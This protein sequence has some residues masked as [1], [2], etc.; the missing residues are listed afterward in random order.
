MLW[1]DGPL[2]GECQ[3]LADGESVELLGP[4]TVFQVAES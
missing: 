3:Y 1:V 4:A 2:R